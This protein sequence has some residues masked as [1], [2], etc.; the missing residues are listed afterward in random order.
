MKEK[1]PNHYKN[2]SFV[3]ND[4]DTFPVYKCLNY[5]T[6]VGTVRHFFGYD[7]SLGGIFSIC[8]SD[9]EKIN[10]FPCHWGWGL[11]DTIIQQRVLQ[12]KINIDRSNFYPINCNEIV[13]LQHGITRIVSKTDPKYERELKNENNINGLSSMKNIISQI[14]DKSL[15][16][17][18]DTDKDIRDIKNTNYVNILEFDTFIPYSKNA[19][20][21]ADLRR[22]VDD[23]KRYTKIIQK[24]SLPLPIQ[25]QKQKQNNSNVK[26]NMNMFGKNRSIIMRHK[27]K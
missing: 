6:Q 13:Q 16:P 10:G 20:Y 19:L 2:I 25:K 12:H 14:S 18:D 21:D 27:F 23:P 8:G 4:I 17:D 15:K 5:K 26:M 3:F 22:K 11:E 9:F 7:F 24:S 1:Y